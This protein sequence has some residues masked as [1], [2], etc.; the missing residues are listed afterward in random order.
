MYV[1]NRVGL[2]PHDGVPRRLACHRALMV[3]EQIGTADVHRLLQ[4]LADA[5][6]EARLTQDAK[7]ALERMSVAQPAP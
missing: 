5:A 4:T 6:P 2:R 7:L 1:T 3:L